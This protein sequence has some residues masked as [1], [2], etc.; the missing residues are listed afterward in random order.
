MEWR[1]MG[2]VTGR[3]EGIE[4]QETHGSIVAGRFSSCSRYEVNPLQCILS[5]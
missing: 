2:L 3:I 4:A 1:H 5:L